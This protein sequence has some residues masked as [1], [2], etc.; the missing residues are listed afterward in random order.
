[1][2]NFNDGNQPNGTT[3]TLDV[4]L[5]GTSTLLAT[6]AITPPSVG[7][8]NPPIFGHFTFYFTADSLSTTLQFTDDG[9]NNTYNQDGILDKVDVEQSQSVPDGG[10]TIG[11]LG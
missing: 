3:Q 2:G 1:Y 5:I 8:A 11:M 7:G 9:A 4:E 10:L 6:T